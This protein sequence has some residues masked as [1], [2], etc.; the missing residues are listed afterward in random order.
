VIT[1]PLTPCTDVVSVS[2]PPE[3]KPENVPSTNAECVFPA[4]I[5]PIQYLDIEDV[6]QTF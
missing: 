5:L 2:P 4:A 6:K 3:M 1:I